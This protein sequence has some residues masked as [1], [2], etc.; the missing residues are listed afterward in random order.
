MQWKLIQYW[1]SSYLNW[2]LIFFFLKTHFCYMVERKVLIVSQNIFIYILRPIWL[3]WWTTLELIVNL[4]LE[5]T[6][7]WSMFECLG[8]QI[9]TGKKSV[10]LAWKSI[11][12]PSFNIL[13]IF[14]FIFFLKDNIDIINEKKRI[15]VYI[16]KNNSIKKTFMAIYLKLNNVLTVSVKNL[17]EIITQCQESVHEFFCTIRDKKK[18][19]P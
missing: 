14:L 9:F 3:A 15:L 8:S 10:Y 11:F 19:W 18:K 13:K 17:K 12:F 5:E 1:F 16:F 2:M 7:L 4:E 6:K